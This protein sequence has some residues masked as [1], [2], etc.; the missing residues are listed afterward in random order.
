M[1]ACPELIGTVPCCPGRRRSGP[2]PHAQGR[3]RAPPQWTTL[4]ALSRHRHAAAQLQRLSSAAWGPH[5]PPAVSRHGVRAADAADVV[6]QCSEDSTPPAQAGPALCV[7]R[8]VRVL[9]CPRDIG[10]SP[11][12]CRWRGRHLLRRRSRL[13][14][15]AQDLRQRARAPST[16]TTQPMPGSRRWSSLVI[17]GRPLPGRLEACHTKRVG[18]CPDGCG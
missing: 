14:L 4:H 9:L 7:S 5:T 11:R 10:R 3:C 15:C 12:L 13:Q 6:I 16:A 18:A 17:L 1:G 2:G 8:L